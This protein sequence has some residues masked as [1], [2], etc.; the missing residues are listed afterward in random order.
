MSFSNVFGGQTLQSNDV[1][2]RAVSL[3]ASITLVWPQF[4][5]SPTDFVAKIMDVTPTG[6]F[7]ITMPPANQVSTGDICLVINRGASTIGILRNDGVTITSVATGQVYYLY[8]TD[9]STTAGTWQSFLY[10]SGSSSLTASS[11]AGYDTIAIGSTL[12]VQHPIVTFS[13]NKNIVASDRGSVQTWTSGTGTLTLPLLSSLSN[14]GFY[15]SVSN[16]GSG[17]LTIAPTGADVID[18]VTSIALQPGDTLM[19]HA[20]TA[21]NWYTIG[22]GRNT[23]FAFTQLTKTV[24]G[25]TTT[26]TQTEASNVIQNYI[27]ALTSNQTV[28][29]P[30]TVQVYYITNS[31]TGNFT[32]TFQT[33]TPGLTVQ[34]A[35]GSSQ[36]LF[37]DGVNVT[38][39]NN[40]IVSNI[41][42]LTLGPG[43]VS[44]PSLSFQGSSTTGLY[45]SL[46]G[47]LDI[48]GGGIKALEVTPG[49][50]VVIPNVLIT[51]GSITGANL[52][53]APIP[54]FILYAQGI[55]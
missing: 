37:C 25:G 29:L 54:D 47:Y 1:A 45:Q 6:A 55:S 46:P 14:A 36:I 13:A 32:L 33:P 2:Y 21:T 41:P 50:Q 3:T 20:A 4:S 19:L 7:N 9:N 53:S 43:S 27:G 17:I 35:Q 40:S 49:G 8:L 15:I 22:R 26:L 16:Q 51:G 48:S 34:S 23:Q 42:S 28:V 38:Q 39:A 10:G 12:N 30:A 18:S 44:N 24:T 11:I 31:T 52:P 5:V